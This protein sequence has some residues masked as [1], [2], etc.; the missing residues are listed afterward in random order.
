[1]CWAPALRGYIQNSPSPQALVL[2]P[3]EPR[4]ETDIKKDKN[5]SVSKMLQDMLKKEK[6]RGVHVPGTALQTFV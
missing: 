5:T 4:P 3:S 1:M 2:F 6:I